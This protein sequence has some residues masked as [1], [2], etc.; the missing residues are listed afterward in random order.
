MNDTVPV[1]MPRRWAIES[2]VSPWRC[3]VRIIRTWAWLRRRFGD[4]CP[5]TPGR[6]LPSCAGLRRP[7]W[8]A[9]FMLSL[10]VPKNRWS[11]L[12]QGGLSQR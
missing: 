4:G 2:I 9:S 5:G 10:R 6:R 11:G 8:A 12:T 1:L 3:A 7:F